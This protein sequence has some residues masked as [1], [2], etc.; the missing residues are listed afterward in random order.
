MDALIE[1]LRERAAD[2]ERRVDARDSQFFS[3][4]KTAGFG[5][6]MGMLGEL[7]PIFGRALA[8][9]R[10]GEVDHDVVAKAEELAAA[11]GTPVES[12]LPAPATPADLERAEAALGVPLSAPLRRV[13]SEIAD[14]GF[15]P[16]YGL[17][18]IER[19]CDEY[20]RLRRLM[21]P[22]G[23]AWPEGLLPVVEQ[24]QGWDCI[25][26]TTGRVVAFDF[27]ELDEDISAAEFAG[28]FQEL[29]PSLEAWLEEWVASPSPAERQAA[30]FAEAEAD[31][32]RAAQAAR[33]T[34]A[35]MTPEE[36]AAMGLPEV[37]WEAVVWGGIG[38]EDADR[39]SESDRL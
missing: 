11:M 13:Y 25:D 17:V 37:G 30:L 2:P 4:L 32:V 15:G 21:E 14:G 10:S 3:S 8:S 24:D 7:R 36:R 16:G 33:E 22:T 23:H 35:R 6:L 39:S 19:V 28:A 5:G 20:G 38:L 31:T 27:E 26:A 29:A 9:S 12:P 1:R 18:S 34:I